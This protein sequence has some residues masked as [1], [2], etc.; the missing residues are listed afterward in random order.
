MLDELEWTAEHDAPVAEERDRAVD[1]LIA[2][3]GAVDGLLQAQA[4]RTRS[5]SSH[6]GRSFTPTEVR[7]IESAILAAYR[8]QYIISMV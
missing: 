7:R 1:D 4:R 2:L 8:W 5:T 3:V 6:R